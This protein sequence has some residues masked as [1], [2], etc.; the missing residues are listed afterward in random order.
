[1]KFSIFVLPKIF[2]VPFES[3]SYLNLEIRNELHLFFYN[4]LFVK[5]SIWT[6]N[7][8]HDIAMLYVI[9]FKKN[10]FSAKII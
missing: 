5:Q 1:M 10:V 9:Y 6:V 8:F 3:Q 2:N 7:G 4:K